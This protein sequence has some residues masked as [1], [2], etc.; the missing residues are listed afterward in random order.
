[1]NTFFS[2]SEILKQEEIRRRLTAERNAR[3][4]EAR[5]A[6][7]SEPGRLGRLASAMRSGWRNLRSDRARSMVRATVGTA[8]N[9]R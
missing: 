7:A 9:S 6:M 1:M 4:H 2:Q 8:D 5:L 3:I